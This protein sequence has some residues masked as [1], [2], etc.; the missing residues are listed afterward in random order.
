[1]ACRTN[2][3]KNPRRVEAGWWQTRCKA[4][5]TKRFLA[6]VRQHLEFERVDSNPDK[7]VRVMDEQLLVFDKAERVLGVKGQNRA[8]FKLPGNKKTTKPLGGK[9]GK[10]DASEPGGASDGG[11]RCERGTFWFACHACGEVV[12][13]KK[14]NCPKR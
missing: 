10:T 1:M 7:A 5:G 8:D 6:A 14:V 4:G 9:Q 12:G 11:T 13:Y 2:Y 3:N